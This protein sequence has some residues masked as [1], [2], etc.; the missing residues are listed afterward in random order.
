MTIY[1]FNKKEYMS[2]TEIPSDILMEMGLHMTLDELS[3][4]CRT[5]KRANNYLCGNDEFW[6]RR[7]LQDYGSV[8]KYETWKETYKG[9]VFSF[10]LNK[11]GQ[12]GLGDR[13]KRD[14]PT[15]FKMFM[16]K[17]LHVE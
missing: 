17:K 6:R 8:E 14:K 13:R 1:F 12:L 2:I 3:A 16:L 15:K 9:K 5:N 10:G 11:F 7:F 4:F